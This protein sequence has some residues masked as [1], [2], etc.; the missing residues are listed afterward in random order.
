MSTQQL[1]ILIDRV[2][3][4]L[5]PTPDYAPSGSALRAHIRLLG[6]V[7]STDDEEQ[8]PFPATITV[9]EEPA[10]EDGRLPVSGTPEYVDTA[11]CLFDDRG[12]LESVDAMLCL[13]A[14]ELRRSEDYLARWAQFGHEPLQLSLTLADA[15]YREQ[16]PIRGIEDYLFGFTMRT[17]DHGNP[18]SG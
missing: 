12:M 5:G 8:D 9:T 2:Q 3:Y 4:L 10:D 13:S 6:S 1:V 17:R 11:R 14:T 16:Q 15:V 7:N 18:E